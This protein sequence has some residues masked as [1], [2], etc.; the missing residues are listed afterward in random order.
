MHHASSMHPRAQIT[1]RDLT[2]ER[3]GSP[4]IRDLNLTV[5]EG[6]RIA[7]V[8]EN[9]RGKST[10]L[11]ALAGLLLPSGGAVTRRGRIGVAEQEMPADDGRTV[12]EAVAFAIRDSIDALAALDAASAALAA[13]G[14]AAEASRTADAY[15]TALD[16]AT[17]LDAWDAD[18]RVTVALEAFDAETDR[19]RPLRELS[20]GQR[21]RVRLA[22]LLGGDAELLLLDEPTNHL[23]AS[24]L[25]FLTESLRGRCGGFVVVSH[26]R[27][28]LRD[29][30]DTLVDLDPGPDGR[31]RVHGGGY[32]GYLAGKTT[33]RARWEQAY[34]EQRETETRLRDDLAA[35]Q[36][37]LVSGWKPPKGTGKHQRA[38]RAPGVVQSV[39]RRQ[40]ELEVHALEVPEPPLRLTVPEYRAALRGTLLTAESVGLEPRLRAPVSCSLRA[41]DRLLVRGPNGA[42]KSTLL[43]ILS[44]VLQPSTGLVLRREGVRIEAL[45]QESEFSRAGS[46]AAASLFRRRAAELVARG[47]LPQSRVVSLDSLGLLGAAER[48]K[49]VRELSIGQQR[50]LDLA[51][52]LLAQPDVLILDEPSNHLSIAL[53]DELMEAL[54]C[55]AA[56]VVVST[57]DRG[58]LRDLAEWEAVSL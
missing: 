17:R 25:D 15:T 57:H 30:A 5:R 23:D 22:C 29:V 32:D 54:T 31:A 11:A 8:G 44:G 2:I 20:I 48:T 36:Q 52:R 56:A 46:L 18:R 35:A 4:V 33:D 19:D 39:R 38:T 14:S 16:T 41:G 50:R 34:A 42:G 27:Q 43:A 10:L 58:M 1:A 6:S 12:G 45:A 24:S 51:L 26:D 49:P 3:G 55:S 47:E 7:V 21:Y 28:L 40:A 13:A 9:G 37:R 53:I